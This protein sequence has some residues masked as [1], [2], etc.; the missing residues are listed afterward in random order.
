MTD[1]WCILRMAGP[2]T[3]TVVK[4]LAEA[5]FTVWTPTVAVT[6]RQGRSRKRKT[7]DTPMMP[8]FAFA[9]YMELPGLLMAS[10]APTSPHPRFR[11]FKHDQGFPRVDDRSLD[12]LRQ[13]EKETR[14]REAR[15]GPKQKFALGAEVR[16]PD[17]AFDGMVGKVVESRK[18]SGNLVLVAFPGLAI[19]VKIATWHLKAVQ[20]DSA[21]PEQGRAPRAAKGK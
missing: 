18:G 6:K 16:A 15:G 4:S 7:V 13:I 14:L 10:L 2:R 12:T 8:T 11:V 21:H 3:L 19:P 20:V 9:D 5:G 1:S 17:T